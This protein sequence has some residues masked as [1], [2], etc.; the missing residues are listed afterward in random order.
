M[1]VFELNT[2][3][4]TCDLCDGKFKVSYLNVDRSKGRSTKTCKTQAEAVNCVVDA[5]LA[6]QRYN[7]DNLSFDMQVALANIDTDWSD[8]AYDTCKA[9]LTVIVSE[10]MGKS[11]T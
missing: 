2:L 9:F 6:T 3:G 11:S 1:T 4:I 10:L 7:W 8:K 5:L